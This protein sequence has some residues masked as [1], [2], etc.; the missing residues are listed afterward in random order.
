MLDG[1][2]KSLTDIFRNMSGKSVI[3][4]NNIKS[5]IQEIRIALLEADVNIS[6]VRSLLSLLRK[7]LSAR[8]LFD[9]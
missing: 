5:A 3:N 1:I 7:S 8:R 2:S 6:V 9:R 4:E